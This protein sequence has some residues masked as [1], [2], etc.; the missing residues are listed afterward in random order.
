MWLVIGTLRYAKSSK[1][2][3]NSFSPIS[4]PDS[5]ASYEMGGTNLKLKLATKQEC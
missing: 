5:V 3:K 1:N 2:C 4:W